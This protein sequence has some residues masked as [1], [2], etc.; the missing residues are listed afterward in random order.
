MI[1]S[2][3]YNPALTF[4]SRGWWMFVV[5]IAGADDI[6]RKG[7]GVLE[8]AASGQRRVLHPMFAP[9]PLNP[10]HGRWSGPVAVI[11][12]DP[13][14]VVVLQDGPSCH[15]PI[16]ASGASKRSSRA[17][18]ASSGASFRRQNRRPVMS[19]AAGR[20]ERWCMLDRAAL[21]PTSSAPS[22]A[23]LAQLCRLL[24]SGADS[25]LSRRAAGRQQPVHG[26]NSAS[27]RYRAGMN[28]RAFP[29][30]R[31]RRARID[32]LDVLEK[33]GGGAHSEPLD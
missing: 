32:N 6:P 15:D 4:S 24:R 7:P 13:E 31:Q 30:S 33:G 10:F 26:C 25:F 2:G 12:I 22:P 29:G 20:S 23:C 19:T 14:A 28:G 1:E 9:D 11:H 3:G 27:L 16:A 18:E 5:D 21:P 8:R 17:T